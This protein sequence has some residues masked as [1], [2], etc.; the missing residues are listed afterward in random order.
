MGVET[1]E[2]VTL[3]HSNKFL[4]DRVQKELVQS[5]SGYRHDVEVDASYCVELQWGHLSSRR[6]WREAS[7]LTN[8]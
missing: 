4:L 5:K 6:D 3:C 1:P 8:G 7:W 2:R